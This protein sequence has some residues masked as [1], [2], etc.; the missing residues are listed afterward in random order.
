MAKTVNS[1]FSQFL[2]NNVRLDSERTKIAKSSKNWL[3]DEI[4]KFPDDGK[5]PPFHPDV[6]IEYGSFSRKTKIR[7]LDDIDMM[8]ILHAQE[9]TYL[10]GIN[11]IDVYNSSN[12]I[13]FTDLCFDGTGQINSIRLINRFK[14]YLAAIPQYKQADIKRNQEAV[15]LELQSYEWTYDIVPCFMTS[16]EWDGRT[17]FLIPDGK[18]R[19]KK[20]DPRIDKKTVLDTQATQ[21]VSIVDVIRLIKYWNCRPIMPSMQSYLLENIVLNYFKAAVRGKW[22]DIEVKNCLAYIADA[23]LGPVPDPKN[24]QGDLNS[25]TWDERNK[26]RKRALEDYQ[27]ATAARNYEREDKIKESIEKW[28]EIFGNEFPTFTLQFS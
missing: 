19:W 26:I 9:A 5:F 14:E 27:R 3:I 25:L 7:P 13:F 8:I 4:K 6:F 21:E 11:S 12:S 24:I 18:G 22:V 20:T 2:S 17:Y 16:P 23:I 10:S 15:S 1:S 28:R